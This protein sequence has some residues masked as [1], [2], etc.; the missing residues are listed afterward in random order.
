[1]N[2]GLDGTRRIETC[3]PYLQHPVDDRALVVRAKQG[4]ESG[5]ALEIRNAVQSV[6]ADQP[7]Y[8]IL[9]LQSVVEA[10]L[11]VRRLALYLLSGLSALALL[12]AAMG[13]Y[14]VISWG[15]V[16]QC[17][18][19]IGIRMALGADR[20]AVLRMVSRE[21]LRLAGIGIGLGLGA[22][23]L[24][25]RTMGSLLFGVRNNDPMTYSTLSAVLLAVALLFARLPA[26]RATKVDPIIALRGEQKK[27]RKRSAMAARKVRRSSPLASDRFT[28]PGLRSTTPARKIHPEGET[29]ASACR[30]TLPAVAAAP[31]A[32]P[33]RRFAPPSTPRCGGPPGWY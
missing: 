1:M 21:G 31:H 4:N 20:S 27:T 10:S 22:S 24:L 14:G 30:R 7:G 11:A 6:D 5:L 33:V 13:L 26:H 9:P 18:Q 17:T 2:Y 16:A 8:D 25:S 23:L 32:S 3:L 15:G 12:L 29:A 19:E 28:V